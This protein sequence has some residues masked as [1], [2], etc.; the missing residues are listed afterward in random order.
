MVQVL[1]QTKKEARKDNK[2]PFSYAEVVKRGVSTRTPPMP[3]AVAVWSAMQTFFPRA[4]DESLRS[5]EIP[6]W[7][8]GTPLRQKFGQIPEGGDPPL[9]RLH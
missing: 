2:K 3:R 8:F 9:L 5:R 6:A 4:E 7:V 1:K